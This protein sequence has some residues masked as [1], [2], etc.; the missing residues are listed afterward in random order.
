MKNLK[1]KAQVWERNIVFIIS[2][3]YV[4]ILLLWQ[5][6]FSQTPDLDMIDD[7]W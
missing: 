3:I 2:A 5:K 7:L 6:L 4:I 1:N